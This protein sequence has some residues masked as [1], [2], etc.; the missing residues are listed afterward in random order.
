MSTSPTT[1]NSHPHPGDWLA[2]EMLEPMGI[3]QYRLARDLH[4]AESQVSRLVNGRIGV[5]AAMAV[6][7]EAYFGLEARFWLTLQENYDL[8]EAR[9]TVDTSDIVPHSA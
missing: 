5:T 7:L 8:A 1:T 9:A 6:K 4:I 3:S 2:T